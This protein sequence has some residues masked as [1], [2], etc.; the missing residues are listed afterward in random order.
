MDGKDMA[1]EAN[2]KVPECDV[3]PSEPEAKLATKESF[4]H[5][6]RTMLR[7]KIHFFL[8]IGGL[9]AVIPFIVVFAKKRLGLSA[10]SLGSVLTS[11]MFIFIFTKPL[12]GYIADYFNRL[13]A[14]ICTLTVINGV[15]MFLLLAIPQFERDTQEEASFAT[16][17]CHKY[18]QLSQFKANI[19]I[20]HCTSFDYTVSSN[21]DE[22]SISCTIDTDYHG[23]ISEK[24]F[25]INETAYSEFV[26]NE[27]K[28]KEKQKVQ[29]FCNDSRTLDHILCL[30][31]PVSLCGNYST[32]CIDSLQSYS[33]L[34][35][36]MNKI[37]AAE[38]LSICFLSS[39]NLLN[40]FVSR[41]FQNTVSENTLGTED[42]NHNIA[43]D[44]Q[45][46][47]FWA[48]AILF[49][50]ASVCGNAI[51][52]LSDTACCESVQ[53]T[54]SDF[55]RQRL[56]GSIGWGV[57]APLAGWL[58]DFTVNFTT[59]WTLMAVMMLLFLYNIYKM[60]L[61]KP[62]FSQN[63]LKDVGTVLKSKEFLMYEAV[64]F[65]N[66]L[67]AGMIWFYLIWFLSSIGGSDFLCGFCLTVQCFGGALP[68]M[69]FSG[70]IIRKVGHF[71]I[72]CLSLLAYTIRFLWYSY[73]YNPWWVLP[74]EVLHG[75]TYGLLCTVLASYGKLSS[76]PG[77]EA[78]TQSILFSTHEGL[79]EGIG[80]IFA[81][82]G[83]DYLGGHQTFFISGIFAACGFGISLVLSFFI[84]K[85][86]GAAPITSQS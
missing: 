1:A 38:S 67:G 40:I 29:L 39:D 85:Q 52:T 60:D 59:S 70:W 76:K 5:I 68:L 4:W 47:Q 37:I 57:T 77:T 36:E 18:K 84:R 3:T 46:V 53:K 2:R 20:L 44:F 49:S 63:I 21:Q 30:C 27:M 14:I 22:I 71:H 65:L 82:I 15:C 17:V 11:Q 64:I 79:G 41:R 75:V 66:G 58:N 45:T 43:N 73:L 28:L 24:L 42:Y 25:V 33:P 74:V 56:W 48:F 8:Y 54:G 26:C 23:N 13:K 51:F 83:F 86:K 72:L 62:H 50:V 32:D 81:G 35:N 31:D 12:I 9:A 6:D 80:C 55:G 78:T 34:L 19:S 69:L 7:F 61:V 16:N 10:T